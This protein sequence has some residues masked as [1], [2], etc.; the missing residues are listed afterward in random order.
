MEIRPGVPVPSPQKP[1]CT[2]KAPMVNTRPPNDSSNKVHT[3]ASQQIY[4][5]A[6][7]PLGAC[8]RGERRKKVQGGRTYFQYKIQNTV[9]N[10]SV[11]HILLL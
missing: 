7:S 8:E 9:K 5:S 2:A 11:V 3:K 6:W 1:Y 4:S 10:F